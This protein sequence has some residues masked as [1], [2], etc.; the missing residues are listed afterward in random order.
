MYRQ[1]HL[2]TESKKRRKIL[3]EINFVG[4]GTF[5]SYSME[6]L[7][8]PPKIFPTLIA[9]AALISLVA[10]YPVPHPGTQSI[11][12]WEG[13]RMPMS[14]EKHSKEALGM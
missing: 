13:Y 9:L 7:Q 6:S 5:S 1:P 14:S 10:S 11:M 8:S 4:S 2:I 3:L 12:T